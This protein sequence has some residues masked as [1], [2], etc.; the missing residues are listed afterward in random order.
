[1]RTIPMPRRFGTISVIVPLLG[2][3]AHAAIHDIAI[4]EPRS[5]SQTGPSI[6]PYPVPVLP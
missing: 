2:S 1:M 4:D 6:R 3:I 5:L